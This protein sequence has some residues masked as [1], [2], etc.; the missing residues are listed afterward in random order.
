MSDRTV[1]EIVVPTCSYRMGVAE[2]GF[3]VTLIGNSLVAQ[4]SLWVG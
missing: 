4:G 2:M 3:G 1:N